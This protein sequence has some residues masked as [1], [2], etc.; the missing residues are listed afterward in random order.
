M[1]LCIMCVA[2]GVVDAQR[3]MRAPYLP[4]I[5]GPPRGWAPWVTVWEHA[6]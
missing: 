5:G 1:V 4:S 3:R 6:V 2:L